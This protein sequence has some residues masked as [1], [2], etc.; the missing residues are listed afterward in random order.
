M[1]LS[2]TGPPIVL[3]L[4]VSQKEKGEQEL[5]FLK[6]S[7]DS[8]LIS[9]EEYMKKKGQIE[10]KLNP[11]KPVKESLAL[12]TGELIWKDVKKPLMPLFGWFS[13]F[14]SGAGM[15]LLNYAGWKHIFEKY[16]PFFSGKGL[17]TSYEVGS[18]IGF[19]IAFFGVVIKLI[20]HAVEGVGKF[21]F[22]LVIISQL[23]GLSVLF[24]KYVSKKFNE[25]KELLDS[26]KKETTHNQK[27]KVY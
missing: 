9:E 2:K 27:I 20:Y 5:R 18:I 25:A 24:S 23:I 16:K 21:F 26:E 14:I 10:S 13:G 22:I 3:D 6:E 12:K 15:V 7:F 19:V 8:K 4:G 17:E 11:N 1:L